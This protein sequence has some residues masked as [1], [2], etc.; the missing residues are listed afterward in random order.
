MGEMGRLGWLG[1]LE[2]L[3]RLG[4]LGRR[5]RRGRRGKCDFTA[6]PL[7]IFTCVG[8]TCISSEERG[9]DAGDGLAA[10][11]AGEGRKLGGG[12]LA[13]TARTEAVA[14][15]GEDAQARGGADEALLQA[16]GARELAVLPGLL[17]LLVG[18]FQSVGVVVL[19]D[20]LE[21]E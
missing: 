11:G 12:E 20:G 21:P 16:H 9:D 8:F 7:L 5:G 2:R 10:G 18:L 4:V 15:R 13:D 3:E 17:G 14:A 6:S 19:R 1:R